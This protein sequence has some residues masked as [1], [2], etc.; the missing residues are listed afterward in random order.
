MTSPKTV[1]LIPAY[2]EEGSITGT[3]QSLKDL[4]PIGQVVVVDD[5]STD[6]TAS[7]S[8]KA[9]ALVVRLER[10]VGKGDALNH[11]LSEFASLDFG[12]LLLI[13][14]DV[15]ETAK[16]ASKLLLPVVRGE[17]DMTIAVFPKQKHKGGF[18]LVKGLARWVIKAK[19]G[20]VME[21][22]LSGQRALRRE[23]LT[24]LGKFARGFGMEVALTI[25]ALKAGFNVK[26]VPVDMTHALTGRDI[27]GFVHRG[28]QFL[29]VLSVL[30]A[31]RRG[32]VQRLSRVPRQGSG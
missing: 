22:P 30:L 10:N 14:A 27:P 12:I 2:N 23:V 26:E 6:N 29:S 19:T 11:A 21:A 4:E 18:G 31:R 25:D 24:A 17:A 32:P 1:A 15:G 28:R 7:L 5:G 9:G 16:E 20:R 13:D 8:K 3:I